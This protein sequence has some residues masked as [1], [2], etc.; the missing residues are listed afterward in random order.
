MNPLTARHRREQMALRARVLLELRRV[1][2]M[3]D[4]ERLDETFPGW[5][6]AVGALVLKN[7]DLSAVLAGRYLRQVR[8]AAGISGPPP[9]PTV[10]AL[11]AAVLMSSLAV[12]GPIAVKRGMS[13]GAG[14]Q[15]AMEAAFVLSANSATRH[16]LNAGREAVMS[17]IS[18]DPRAVGWRRVTSGRA[19]EFCDSLQDTYP[20]GE[21][22]FKAHDGCGCSAEPAYQ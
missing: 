13:H 1:W 18:E 12:T 15:R 4:P 9:A 11:P 8:A 3:L 16:V 14:V 17:S 20:P 22:D 5:A 7:R 19:C 2:P 6:T 10:A 21:G